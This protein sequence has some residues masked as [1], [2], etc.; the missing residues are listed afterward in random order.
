MGIHRFETVKRILSDL[1]LT[2][3]SFANAALQL[4]L[5]VSRLRVWT[6][7]VSSAMTVTLQFMKAAASTLHR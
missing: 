4:Q 1:F 5:D 3:P 2:I 6:L 7:R